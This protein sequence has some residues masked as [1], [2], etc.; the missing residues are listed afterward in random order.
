MISSGNSIGYR[1]PPNKVVRNNS[2]SDFSGWWSERPNIK[3]ETI[4]GD[5]KLI[6]VGY[7]AEGKDFVSR[8]KKQV[9]AIIDNR[10]KDTNVVSFDAFTD[11]NKEIADDEAFVICS[12]K[13]FDELYEMVRKRFPDAL[14]VASYQFL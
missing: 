12:T 3:G 2:I 14:I 7:G 4:I 13:Y 5:K 11:R 10:S 9:I 6:V 1:I 8:T